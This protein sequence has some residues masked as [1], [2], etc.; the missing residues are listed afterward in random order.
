MHS[1]E[2]ANG[3]HLFDAGGIVLGKSVNGCRTRSCNSCIWQDKT[4][5][6]RLMPDALRDHVSIGGLAM[7]GKTFSKDKAVRLFA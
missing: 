1:I 6:R 4:V 2:D 7:A 5:G 3:Q